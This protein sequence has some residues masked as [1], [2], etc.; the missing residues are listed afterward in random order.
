MAVAVVVFLVPGAQARNYPKIFNSA[1]LKA[2]SWKLMRGPM[3]EFQGMLG[4]WQ[5]GKACE[6]PICTSRSWPS[7]VAKVKALAGNPPAEIALVNALVNDKILHPYKEDPANWQKDE[8]WA[9]AFQFLKK[10]GDCEDYAITKYMLLK[11]A[12]MPIE[13][14]R[15]VAVA[16][17]N[18]NGLGHTILVVY[19]GDQA[20]VL[21]NR[22]E[23]LVETKNATLEYTA[24]YSMNESAWWRHS[25]PPR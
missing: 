7:L 9:T 8:Y 23:K 22:Y 2:L 6:T 1:E 19:V 20:W 12:G 13:N 3:G 11:A 18:R 15:I 5:D 10:S 21:D 17:R 16:L 14:M 24:L 25:P 4:T